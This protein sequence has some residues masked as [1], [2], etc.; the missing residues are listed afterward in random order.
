[1]ISEKE[2]KNSLIIDIRSE[3]LEDVNDVEAKNEFSKRRES[4]LKLNAYVNSG[5]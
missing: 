5:N 4:Y 2:F 1:M 3:H